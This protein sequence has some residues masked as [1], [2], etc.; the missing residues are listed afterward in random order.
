[1]KKNFAEIKK[2]N[3]YLRSV[4]RHFWIRNLVN[5]YR[6]ICEQK[7]KIRSQWITEAKWR[8]FPTAV[9]RLVTHLNFKSRVSFALRST[10][11][12]LIISLPSNEQVRKT[13]N[14][15]TK[16]IGTK[17]RLQ[18]NS[19]ENFIEILMKFKQ[20]WRNMNEILMKFKE[21]WKNLDEILMKF[22]KH[23]EE[24]LMKFWRTLEKILMKF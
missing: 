22:S 7:R 24:I 5:I 15:L 23:F 10:N 12:A 19:E 2:R 18:E 13:D 1:M 21:L 3:S 20:F 16:K 8:Q 14:W 6:N 9:S 11:N 17:L 4:C